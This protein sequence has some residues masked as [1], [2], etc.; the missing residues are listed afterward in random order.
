MEYN[1]RGAN[2]IGIYTWTNLGDTFLWSAEHV[3]W[4]IWKVK[5][6]AGRPDPKKYTLIAGKYWWGPSVKHPC[7][8]EVYR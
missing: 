4:R 6:G 2:P 8:G 1:S 3:F 5:T 7:R